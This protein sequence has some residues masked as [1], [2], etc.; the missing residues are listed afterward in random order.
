MHFSFE[1]TEAVRS[2][3][4]IWAPVAV[5]TLVTIGAIFGGAGFW[6]YKQAQ[7]QAKRDKESKESGVEN[8]VDT[9]TNNMTALNTKVDNLS[10]DMKGLKAD[11]ALL[12]QANEETI[13]YRN[14]RD[15]ADQATLQERHAIIESLKGLMRERLL[16]VYNKCVKKGFYTKEERE[17][18]KPLY[19]CYKDEPF[20][21]NGVIKDLHY[22]MIRLPLEC[23]GEPT[24]GDE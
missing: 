14:A 13:K 15:S 2:I 24:T 1:T 22:I 11:L 16:D 5:Q 10:H 8:K 6:Q 20:N 4:E 7:L 21:G 17:V 23:D 3:W 9:L 18:Y 12:Q 19:E